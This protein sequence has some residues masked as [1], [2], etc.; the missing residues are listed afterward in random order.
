MNLDL[1]ELED[2]LE[3]KRL[4]ILDIEKR[5]EERVFGWGERK[6]ERWLEALRLCCS[7]NEQ[8]GSKPPVSVS[9]SPSP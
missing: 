2:Y 7:F 3:F 6:F 5:S 1:K 8:H 4:R 9:H